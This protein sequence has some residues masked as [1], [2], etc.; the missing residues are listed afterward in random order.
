MKKLELGSCV[1]RVDGIGKVRPHF[2][3]TKPCGEPLIVIAVNV[4]DFNTHYDHT[5]V[6]ETEHAS[7]KKKSVVAYRKTQFWLVAQIEAELNNNE[8][9]T[10][11]HR[12]DPVCSIELVKL[13]RKGL[14]KSTATAEKFKRHLRDNEC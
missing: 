10:E 4:T 8:E 2:V 12:P 1:Y 7:I 9:R 3:I 11:L 13:L 6:L 14:M 5:V